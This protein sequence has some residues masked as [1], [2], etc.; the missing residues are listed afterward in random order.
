MPPAAGLG[1]I[2]PLQGPSDDVALFEKVQAEGFSEQH[3]PHSSLQ[4]EK[5]CPSPAYYL[6]V[7]HTHTYTDFK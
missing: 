6:I 3:S 4:P 1:E 7:I 2:A 5:F